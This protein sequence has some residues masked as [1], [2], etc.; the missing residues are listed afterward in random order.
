MQSR[1]P[2]W[3]RRRWPQQGSWSHPACRSVRWQ[4]I[5]IRQ[6][7]VLCTSCHSTP[8]PGH[9]YGPLGESQL[10]SSPALGDEPLVVLQTAADDAAGDREVAVVAAQLVDL[11]VPGAPR[12]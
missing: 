10:L 9:T 12:N 6:Y 7:L 2:R 3:Q 5:A 4:P 1:Q 8:L 11:S